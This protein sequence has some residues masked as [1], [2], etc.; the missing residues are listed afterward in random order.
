MNLVK[1]IVCSSILLL[2]GG[3]VSKYISRSSNQAKISITY[4][5]GYDSDELISVYNMD[6]VKDNSCIQFTGQSLVATV[7]KGNPLSPKTSNQKNILIDS[8][9]PIKLRITMLPATT[10]GTML[11]YQNCHREIIFMPKT[12]HSYELNLKSPPCDVDL[13]ENGLKIKAD[14]RPT[15]C[16]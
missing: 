12:S 1:I 3:C 6:N 11:Q 9:K 4:F 7:N 8:G 15:P 14:I 16:L 10:I 13:S 5:W 2:L